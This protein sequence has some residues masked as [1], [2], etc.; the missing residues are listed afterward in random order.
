MSFLALCLRGNTLNSRIV[1]EINLMAMI[2]KRTI[3]FCISASLLFTLNS[4]EVEDVGLLRTLAG[5]DWISQKTGTDN[6]I[7]DI[8][9]VNSRQGWALG[10]ETLIRTQNGG[11]T[12]EMLS[13]PVF[14][15]GGSIYFSDASNG[16]INAIDQSLLKTTDGGNTWSTVLLNSYINQFFSLNA[17]TAW[18]TTIDQTML[19][20]EDGGETWA[21][22]EFLYNVTVMQFVNEQV[23]WVAGYGNEILKT[24][25]GGIT[26]ID[27]SFDRQGN[28]AEINDF[29]SG[30]FLDEN[31]GWIIGNGPGS[32]NQWGSYLLK[33]TDGGQIWES[34][35]LGSNSYPPLAQD[36]HF[37]DSQT[38]YI[39]GSE[40]KRGIILKSIDGGE[41]W[42][43]ERLL[44]N[45]YLYC[46][47]VSEEQ[48]I[49]AGGDEGIILYNQSR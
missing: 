30:F 3:L 23:G 31:T 27:Q 41:T 49:W 6:P 48:E 2:H 18:A 21:E 19:K 34:Q 42:N 46:L 1:H 25:D 44:T 32:G 12:W 40:D 33:T 16:W 35:L 24:E 22:Y 45:K 47:H 11:E 43:K 4:C 5:D 38:G 26:W 15:P 9:F 37:I 8:T 20:T 7:R 17:Q 29:Q 28:Q 36:I 39:V 13:L 10:Y 14:V